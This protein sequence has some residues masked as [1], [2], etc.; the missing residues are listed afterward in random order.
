MNQKIASLIENYLQPLLSF[1]PFYII[2]DRL[3]RASW[4]DTIEI[5]FIGIATLCSLCIIWFISNWRSNPNPYL[6][7]LSMVFCTLGLILLLFWNGF[8]FFYILGLVFTFVR[9]S[10]KAREYID[11]DDQKR[12]N[13]LRPLLNAEIMIFIGF[14][15]SFLVAVVFWDDLITYIVIGIELILI[16][17]VWLVQLRF[18][19]K[20]VSESKKI[21]KAISLAPGQ[22]IGNLFLALFEILCPLLLVVFLILII[23]GYIPFILMDAGTSKI[24]AAISL[25]SISTILSRI[26]QKRR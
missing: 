17:I 20:P 1:V 26:Y 8:I 2:F 13:W 7:V 22:Y 10:P 21:E 16:I 11:G 5:I 25:A 4:L 6:S 19:N 15:I 12:F 3:I 14:S 18:R 9:L 24:I 23:R